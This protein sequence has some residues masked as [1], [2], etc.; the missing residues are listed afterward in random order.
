VKT[1]TVTEFKANPSKYLRYAQAGLTVMLLERKKPV[2]LLRP[3]E[4]EDE[5]DDD[6]RRRLTDLGIAR[7]PA[8]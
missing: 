6:V 7:P 4:P 1:A 2:A 8:R 3:I 5:T